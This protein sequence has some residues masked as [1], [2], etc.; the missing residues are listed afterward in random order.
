MQS[1]FDNFPGTRY[2]GSKNKIIQDIWGL[3]KDLP[4]NSVLDAFG[5]SNVMGYFLKTKGKKVITNDFMTYSYLISK[6]II[7][8]STVTLTH[9]DIQKLVLENNNTRF[10]QNTFKDIFFSDDDNKFLDNVRN[11]IENLDCEYKKSL[12][13][14]SLARACVKKQ[15]R[16]I[17]TF[18]G[19]RYNDGRI[20]LQKT[21][22]EHFIEGINIYNNAVFDNGNSN[23][24]LNSDIRNIEIVDVPDLV[25][26]DPPYYSQKSDNDY[27]RRYHFVEGLVRKWEGLEIQEKSVVKKF[28][29]YPSPFSRKDTA[30]LAFEDLIEKFKKS[31]IVISYSSNSLPTKSEIT[32]ML[33]QKKENVTVFEINHLY[34]MGN[35]G[36]KKGNSN[37][38]IK[39]YLFVAR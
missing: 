8:N 19:Q 34:S 1:K 20:D 6:S 15:S 10:I 25:Y 5:G 35:Q 38:R 14:S 39:E 2:M 36:H 29:S 11:N 24:S 22:S 28:K 3:I 17:F 26:L 12:A 18:K 37:N 7:E 30:Y 31:I 27:V 13:L 9:D 21:I 23:L 16:G 4:F 32:D 33:L